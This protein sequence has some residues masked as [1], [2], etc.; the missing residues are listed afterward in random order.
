MADTPAVPV[1]P[2]APA[3]PPAPA[4]G[5]KP[6]D[7]APAAP[8]K[9]GEKAPE[10][11][12]EVKKRK[13]K[14]DG[15][16]FEVEESKLDELVQKGLGAD[17]RFKEAAKYREQAEMLVDLL[18][19]KPMALL[20]KAAKEN[21]TDLRKMLEDY[22]WEN[23]FKLE[24]MKPEE[25]QAE[26]N[27]RKLAELEAEK[28][29]RQTAEERART[30]KLQEHY[31]GEFERDIMSAL[32]AG[33]IPRTPR[34][35][36]RMA[37]YMAEGLKQGVK[38]SA[39]DVAPLVQEDYQSDFRDMFGKAT[40]DLLA[41]ILGDEGLKKLRDFEMARLGAQGGGNPPPPPPPPAGDDKPNETLTKEQWR[42]R[43]N[44]RVPLR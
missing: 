4:A 32:D 41:K 1:V 37:Y 22:L 13:Y 9:P 26:E 18:G 3:A 6:G 14:V 33:G 17:K 43:L 2:A 23:F 35:V 5:G 36:G 28:K 15:Q 12:A 7:A 27:R 25:R 10:T 39:K 44:K 19:K 42:E 8:A 20:E 24:G 38:L 21:G 34:T 30:Q 16:D 11:P 29:E 40:P 31:R